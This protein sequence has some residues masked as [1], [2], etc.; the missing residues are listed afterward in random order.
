MAYNKV[1]KRDGFVETLLVLPRDE[2]CHCLVT[3]CLC[4]Q[5]TLTLSVYC[6]SLLCLLCGAPG[7]LAELI[8]QLFGH[9]SRIPPVPQRNSFRPIHRLL[10]LAIP[11]VR[12][13]AVPINTRGVAPLAFRMG[14]HAA[15]NANGRRGY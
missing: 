6:V 7:L 11:P 2:E 5:H 9:L 15:I 14:C 4:P 1:V 13:A 10:T 3:A 8:K 12:P